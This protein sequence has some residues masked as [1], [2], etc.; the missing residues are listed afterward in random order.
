MYIDVVAATSYLVCRTVIIPNASRL[1]ASHMHVQMQ[2]THMQCGTH[3][4]A[5]TQVRNYIRTYIRTYVPT[6]PPTYVHTH[7][8]TDIQMYVCRYVLT[9]D[10]CPSDAK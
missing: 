6:F 10:S 5:Y 9:R 1:H 7:I 2:N 8:Q 3:T 4:H